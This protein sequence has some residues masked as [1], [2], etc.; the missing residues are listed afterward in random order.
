MGAEPLLKFWRESNQLGGGGGG[1]GGGGD[2]CFSVG[3]TAN[4]FQFFSIQPSFVKNIDLNKKL[5]FFTY[6]VY[7][8][9]N[10]FMYLP[11]LLVH[12][13]LIL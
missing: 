8:S 9:F 10:H 3:A 7:L 11:K 4:E 13:L 6:I 2:A 1:E 12:A 5:K